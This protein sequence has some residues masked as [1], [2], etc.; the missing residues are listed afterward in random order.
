MFL[1]RS[2]VVAAGAGLF[3]SIVSAQLRVSPVDLE[4][5]AVA[6]G[7][8]LRQLKTTAVFMQATAHPDD[9]NNA[10]HVYL[11]RGLGMRTVLATATRGDGGQNEI[12]SELYDPLAVLRTEELEAMH[13][14]DGSE[15]YFTRAI[16][17]GYSFSIEETLEKWGRDE[18]IADYVRLIRMTRP[19]V[20]LGMSPSG[21][22][23]GL[24][25]QTSGLL[26][27]EAFKA[28]GDPARYPEHIRE[29]LMP[30]QPRKYYYP[31]GG[32]GGGR[33]QPVPAAGPLPLGAL[34][35][36][37][38]D[39]SLFD[40]LLGRTYVEIGTEERGMHKS[41]A[42][43]QLLALPSGRTQQRYLL[44]D[45]NVP[46]QNAPGEESSLFNGI[47]TSIEGLAAFA[48]AAPPAALVSGLQAIAG[49][50]AAAQQQFDSTAPFAAAPAISAGLNAV[51]DLRQKLTSLGLDAE[52]RFNLDARLKT[53]EEQFTEAALLANGLRIEVLADDGLVVPGQDIRVSVAIGDRGRAVTV[54]SVALDGFATAASCP[55]QPLDVGAVYRC[56]TAT[57][58]PANARIT[59]PY[60][61]ALPKLARYE[62]EPDAPFGLP[63]RPTPFRAS[64]TLTAD[65][66]ELHVNRPVEFR[67]EGQQLEGEK[68][69]E[70]TVVPRLAL[71]V[72][73]SIAIV[74]ACRG[75]TAA[76]NREVRITVA[77]HGKNAASGEV[78]MDTPSGWTLTP[79]VQQVNFTRE[80]EAQ[81]VRFTLSPAAKTPLAQYLVKSVA[82]AGGSTFDTGFQTVEYQHIRR[83]QLEIPAQVAVKVMDVRLAP[84]LVIGYVMG[85]GDEIPAALR[86]LGA[87]VQLLDGDELAWGD[88]T[89]FDA[90]VVGVRAYDSREDLRANNKRVL[91]YA[92]AGGTVIVQYN[93]GNT[94]TQ[95]APFPARFSNTRVTDENGPVKV[96]ASDDPV[97]HFPNEIG[98]D[99]WKNWVQER[100]TYFIVPDD[101]RYT[102]LIEIHEPF[103]HNV[104]W[105]RGALVSANVGKGRWI[106]VGLGLWRQVAAGTDGAFQLLANLASRGK[107]GKVSAGGVK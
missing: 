87:T 89:R 67:Y 2:T 7:L 8:A 61:K 29:G 103:E 45:S 65:G 71:R 56:D 38:F 42:M 72:T 95:Y 90:I 17:F 102:D 70:L 92:S 58:I 5:G 24:H 9:E 19:D 107:V 40:P 85:T 73:P 25:H 98:E 104:G 77:N 50:V 99:A 41:Q 10:L 22:A 74:P 100:G 57:Q 88:L 23:G 48:G 76:V 78:R 53:K 20:V 46:S 68:R 80:D 86:G 33:G 35:A 27:R 15:Q 31:A 44:M 79:P 12:G 97:F 63:F 66:R 101:Q 62:F 59:K 32:P 13:R 6:L 60:W 96:L 1:K 54:S 91:D 3:I 49:H 84:S 43:A 52:A 47:D 51:R 37:T 55:S 81:T 83:R 105:K 69:M 94:W 39:V 16:D 28:A 18:I 75:A 64:I 82:A 36:A 26:S 21:T 93:R 106:Y 4:D 14:F 11:N 30:W 34:K